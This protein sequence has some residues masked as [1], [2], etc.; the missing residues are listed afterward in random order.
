MVRGKM[1]PEIHLLN[2]VQDLSMKKSKKRKV[3]RRNGC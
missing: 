1:R 2:S 3:F